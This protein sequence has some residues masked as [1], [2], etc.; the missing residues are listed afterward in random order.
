MTETGRIVVGE[1]PGKQPGFDED[2][3]PIANPDH[4]PASIDEVVEAAYR[5]LLAGEHP[6]PPVVT[7]R[8]AS[9][10]S[11]EDHVFRQRSSRRVGKGVESGGAKRL[12]EVAVPVG[13]GEDDDG[14]SRAAHGEPAIDTV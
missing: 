4:Q 12:E 2:L 14:C 5:R 13:A 3:E 7:E 1:R 8:E 10:K 9:G 6:R 11:G